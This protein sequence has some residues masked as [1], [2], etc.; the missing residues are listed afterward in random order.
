MAGTLHH[1]AKIKRDALKLRTEEVPTEPCPEQT[2][3][4][5]GLRVHH[6]VWME[7]SVAILCYHTDSAGPKGPLAAPGERPR[8]VL[9]Q[10]SLFHHLS[11]AVDLKDAQASPWLRFLPTSPLP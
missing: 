4:L 10:G 7:K 2:P 8:L 3:A 11:L 1:A 9:Q 5:A 6:W